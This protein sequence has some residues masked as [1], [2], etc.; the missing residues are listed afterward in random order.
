MFEFN[1][2]ELEGII[3]LGSHKIIEKDSLLIIYSNDYLY[4]LK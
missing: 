1:V 2:G 4:L 3:D